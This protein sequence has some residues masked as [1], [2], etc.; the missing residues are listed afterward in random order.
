VERQFTEVRKSVHE[1]GPAKSVVGGEITFSPCHA[2]KRE[3]K[4]ETSSKKRKI[5]QNRGKYPALRMGQS[6]KKVHREKHS[7]SRQ[8]KRG[9]YGTTANMKKG[10][11]RPKGGKG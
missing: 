6:G 2:P 3:E 4:R 9:K 7:S 5:V 1:M 8:R 10:E 11:I